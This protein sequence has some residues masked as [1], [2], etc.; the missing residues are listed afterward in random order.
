VLLSGL[1]RRHLYRPFLYNRILALPRIR[2][3]TSVTV[4]NLGIGCVACGSSFGRFPQLISL[5]Y[6]SSPG[7]E[8]CS[9]TSVNISL[10]V[11]S[12]IKSGPLLFCF[13]LLL[14]LVISCGCDTIP[15][16]YS[17]LLFTTTTTAA[18]AATAIATNTI[19]VNGELF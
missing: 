14:G 10:S 13:V 2:V 18:A 7:M 1:P 17:L 11:L 6:R 19:E 3:V 8:S 12:S 15:S 5:P 9:C 16:Y 4:R